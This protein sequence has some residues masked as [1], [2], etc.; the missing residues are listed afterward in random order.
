MSYTLDDLSKIGDWGGERVEEL[1]ES[2]TIEMI[3]TS[4]N[5]NVENQRYYVSD[6]DLI[7]RRFLKDA[8]ESFDRDVDPFAECSLFEDPLQCIYHLLGVEKK[9][10]ELS[11]K[12]YMQMGPSIVSVQDIFKEIALPGKKV[13]D[14]STTSTLIHNIRILSL[15]TNTPIVCESLGGVWDTKWTRGDGRILWIR[16]IVDGYLGLI[17]TEENLKTLGV[18]KDS[19]ESTII[20]I[21]PLT[22]IRKKVGDI[23]NELIRLA[24][25]IE[26]IKEKNDLVDIYSK[27]ILFPERFLC[28]VGN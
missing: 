10:R 11:I 9:I 14:I 7:E 25:P 6:T 28:Q 21:R 13:P 16:E 12:S 27:H 4:S 20:N 24:I 2:L 17:D 3:S 22:G 18:W 15:I 26:G 1:D 8:T 5:E 19:Y 23:R